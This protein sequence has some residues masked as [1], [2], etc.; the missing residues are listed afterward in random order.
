MVNRLNI[1]CKKYICNSSYIIQVNKIFILTVGFSLFFVLQR[2]GKYMEIITTKTGLRYRE[3]E[4]RNAYDTFL[5]LY[6][7][8][9]SSFI[10]H[11]L[12]TTQDV[13]DLTND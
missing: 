9:A 5:I 11:R 4:N 2:Y 7:L 8:N 10:Q 6:A 13:P 1:L 3:K 12:Y